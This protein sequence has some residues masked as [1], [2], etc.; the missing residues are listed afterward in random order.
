[1]VDVPGED[2]A[3]VDKFNPRTMGQFQ[4]KRRKQGGWVH[5]QRESQLAV[6]DR[7]APSEQRQVGAR[8]EDLW[9]P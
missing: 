8:H 9:V 4:H 6:I 5:E 1:M 7:C 2:G 3:Q